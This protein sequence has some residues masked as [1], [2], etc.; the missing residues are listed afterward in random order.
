MQGCNPCKCTP[1]APVGMGLV[2]TNFWQPPYPYPN[3]GGRLCPHIVLM[4][5]PSFESHG[6]ACT[7]NI[8]KKHKQNLNTS[9]TLHYVLLR[10]PPNFQSFRRHPKVLSDIYHIKTM[11]L[12]FSCT[13]FDDCGRLIVAITHIVQNLRFVVKCLQVDTF[14]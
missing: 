10:A 3:K 12:T 1:G 7:P 5:P 14:L 8:L 13:D 2:P 9:K 4:S 6:R 11:Y